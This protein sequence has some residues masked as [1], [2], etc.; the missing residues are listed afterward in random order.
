MRL[1][2]KLSRRLDAADELIQILL[3]P[4]PKARVLLAL[5]RHAESFGEQ[6]ETGVHIHVSAIDLAHEVGIDSAVV[7]DIFTRLRRLRI[8]VEDQGGLTIT[9]VGRL[10]DFLEFLDM[11]RKFE[12]G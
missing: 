1:I 10:H 11:P 7:Q 8:A 12:G 9:D 5:K 2:T 3:N 6:T 4:D